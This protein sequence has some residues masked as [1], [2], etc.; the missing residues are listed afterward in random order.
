MS[1]NTGNTTHEMSVSLHSNCDE[2]QGLRYFDAQTEVHTITSLRH[3]YGTSVIDPHSFMDL[4]VGWV[5]GGVMVLPVSGNSQERA[6]KVVRQYRRYSG[7]TDYMVHV[8]RRGSKAQ[9]VCPYVIAAPDLYANVVGEQNTFGPAKH[10]V[11]RSL[12]DI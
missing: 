11:G 5:V 7:D 6:F 10:L 2:L 9:E 8:V 3:L 4:H 12:H 1:K